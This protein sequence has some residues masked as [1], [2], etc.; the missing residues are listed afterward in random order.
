[1]PVLA[2]GGITTGRVR[3]CIEAGA[4]GVAAVRLFQDSE[5]LGELMRELR[6]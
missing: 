5:E 2:I 1:M 4:A 6:A 3:E